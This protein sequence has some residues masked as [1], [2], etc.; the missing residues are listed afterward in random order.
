MMRLLVTRA[1]ED[2]ERTAAALRSLGHSVLL[3]P[4]LRIE[5]LAADFGRAPFAAVLVTSANAAG[6]V[7]GH[8]R[9]DE[10]RNVPLYTVGGRSAGAARAA[11]FTTVRSADGD[12]QDLVRLVAQ[13]LAGAAAPLLY[14]AGED[15]SVDLGD[16]LGRHGLT[17][18]TAVVYRAAAAE[19]LPREAG[20]AIARGELDGVLH[21]SPRSASIFMRCADAANLRE[22]ALALAHFCLSAQV[23]AAVAAAGAADVRTAARPEELALLNLVGSA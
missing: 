18:R 8:T 11:G 23:A 1:L 20:Q 4:L 16:E 14:L 3:A 17:V 15:R 22:R 6:A 13:Q 21:Y 2:G 5:P 12:A 10:L 7:A 19:R 9:I